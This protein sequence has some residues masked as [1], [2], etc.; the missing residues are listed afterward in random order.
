MI[1]MVPV[2]LGYWITSKFNINPFTEKEE[3]RFQTVLQ[4]TVVFLNIFT[5]A[6]GLCTQI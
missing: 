2:F 1:T 3:A 6:V 5:V 4:Y